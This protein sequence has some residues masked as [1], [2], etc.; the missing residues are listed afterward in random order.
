M[1]FIERVS[2]TQEAYDEAFD[3]LFNSWTGL[4]EH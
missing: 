2:K 1:V 4:K 3:L